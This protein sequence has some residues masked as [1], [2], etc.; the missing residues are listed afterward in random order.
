VSNEQEPWVQQPGESLVWY[1]RFT[2]FRLME[3]VR[4]IAAVFQEVKK[5]ESQSNIPPGSWYEAAKQ[6]RW[7]E[8]AAAWDASLDKQIEQQIA[9]ERKK[10]LRSR[11]ALMHKRIEK[12]D[13]IAQRLIGYLDD[14]NNVWLPDVKAI[15]T[16]PNARQ[17]DLIRFN[18]P[19][20]SEIRGYLADIA[21]EKGERVKKSEVSL[22]EIPKLYLDTDPNEDGID[23]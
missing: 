1:K 22:K 16:G 11:Y 23:P 5:G 17:V 19:L 8:R 4:S 2:R 10:V 13:E 20:F 9:T 15:G 21:A 12:L 18:A 3:P 6:W 7:E 14:E